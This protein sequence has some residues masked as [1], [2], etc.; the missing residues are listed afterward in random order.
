M[1]NMN[2]KITK[3]FVGFLVS[4]E[5]IW[6]FLFWYF[7]LIL[8]VLFLTDEIFNVLFLDWSD[9]SFAISDWLSL[10]EFFFK[11]ELFELEVTLLWLSIVLLNSWNLKPHK[12][13]WNWFEFLMPKNQWFDMWFRLTIGCRWCW[14]W[15]LHCTC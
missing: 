11:L 10:V 15:I 12:S 13:L 8:S 4:F 3:R 14:L 5:S 9:F 1:H 2:I 6:N 7:K